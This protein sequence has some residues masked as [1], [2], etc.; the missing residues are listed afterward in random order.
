MRAKYLVIA[1]AV[2]LS[3]V[4]G[5]V[6]MKLFSTLHATSSVYVCQVG[7]YKEEANA[8][9]MKQKLESIQIPAYIYQ[10]D[11]TFIVIGDIFTSEEEANTLGKKISENQITCIVREYP[12]SIGLKKEVQNKQYENVYK[13][14][15]KHHD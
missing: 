11:A 2:M 4:F 13:E 1:I 15:A 12:I 14:L 9:E 8:N 3:I 10:K 6:Y 7:I 5:F